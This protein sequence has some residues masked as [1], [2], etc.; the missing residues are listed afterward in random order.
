MIEK[1]NDLS[2]SKSLDSNYLLSLFHSKNIETNLKIA[3]I[4]S[5][6]ESNIDFF[7]VYSKAKV[8]KLDKSFDRLKKK[9]QTFICELTTQ[10]KPLNHINYYLAIV[11][12]LVMFK[13]FISRIS[14]LSD[15]LVNASKDYISSLYAKEQNEDIKNILSQ[16]NMYLHQLKDT[17]KK[18][19]SRMSTKS[20]TD[21][22]IEDEIKGI[23]TP[24]FV[25]F[26][27]GEEQN[28]F[29]FDGGCHEQNIIIPLYLQKE[30]KKYINRI[31][32]FNKKNTND[33]SKIKVNNQEALLKLDLM[34]KPKPCL[35]TLKTINEMFQSKLITKEDRSLL[36]EK[37]IEKDITFLSFMKMSLTK[38]GLIN[39]IKD[40]LS[41]CIQ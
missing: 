24:K 38:E 4:V 36:K 20:N 21:K 28:S 10:E 33:E 30:E 12:R 35:E 19:I 2:F 23:P 16:F 32:L 41:K 22:L 17:T 29:S 13:A 34:D 3:S 37:L 5:Q 9:L 27:T 1:I 14:S 15:I 7:S 40:Y 18:P 6:Y 39:K 8:F 31:N 25:G 11:T 26:E